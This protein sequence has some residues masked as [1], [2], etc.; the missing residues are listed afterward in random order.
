M[1]AA[2]EIEGPVPFRVGAVVSLTLHF[3][4][5][6]VVPDLDSHEVAK[7][8]VVVHSSVSPDASLDA[9]CK[10]GSSRERRE[11]LHDDSSWFAVLW[12]IGEA[13]TN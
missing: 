7:K 13:A 4:E 12:A 10:Q 1:V 9:R 6:I 2:A 8:G 11:E 3:V 5:V